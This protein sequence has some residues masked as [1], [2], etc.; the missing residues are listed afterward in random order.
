MSDHDTTE[1]TAITY[2][3][4]EEGGHSEELDAEDMDE[5]LEMAEALCKNGDWGREGASV[6]VWVTA[7]DENGEEID[8]EEITVEIEPDYDYLIEQAGGDTSC[9]HD[10]TGEGEGGCD[11]NPGVWST[12]GTSMVFTR[13]CRTC[14]LHRVEKSCGS[15]RNPGEHDTVQYTQPERWCRECESDT[16]DCD[17]DDE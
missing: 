11:Q 3:Y 2:T 6:T 13:H 5:A 12:G 1:E 9:D 16:C 4:H 10:W 15:Q 14:G 8:R 7:E 17:L